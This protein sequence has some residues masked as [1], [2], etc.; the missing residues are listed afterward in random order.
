MA[1]VELRRIKDNEE[2]GRLAFAAKLLSEAQAIL[3]ADDNDVAAAYI[4]M[5]VDQC[6]KRLRSAYTANVSARDS[7]NC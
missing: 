3:E 7:E 6:D 1:K 2:D 5:A 4:Q